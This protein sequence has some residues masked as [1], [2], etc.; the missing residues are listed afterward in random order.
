MLIIIGLLSEVISTLIMEETGSFGISI[1]FCQNA[2]CHVPEKK[3][4]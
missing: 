4:S 3:S 1:P 2:W